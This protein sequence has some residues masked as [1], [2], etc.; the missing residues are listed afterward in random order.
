MES[1]RL[2]VFDFDKT[3]ASGDS[4]TEFVHFL[5]EKRVLSLPRLAVMLLISLLWLLRLVPVEK[6]K[7][8]ALAAL[9]K[10]DQ[11]R[12]QAL[13]REFVETRLVPR[14]FPP[15]LKKLQEHHLAGDVVLLVSASPACYLNHIK[16]CL[17]L[18]AVLATTTDDAYRVITNVRGE[19]KPRQVRQWLDANG[20][21]AD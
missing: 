16:H 1:K 21:T 4:I 17:P 10:V 18:E 19:E 15:A 11:S 13:C 3:M 20:I 5:W 2:A 9:R 8:Q 12:A 14:I 7:N 6:A